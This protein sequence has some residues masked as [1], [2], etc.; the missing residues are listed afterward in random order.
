MAQPFIAVNNPSLCQ[1]GVGFSTAFDQLARVGMEQFLLWSM[2][3]GARLSPA[4]A[5][6]QAVLIIRLL[7]GGVLV[8]FTRPEF[9]PACV[10]RNAV[11]PIAIVALVLDF[12]IGGL[13]F[14]GASILSASAGVQGHDKRSLSSVAAVLI[15]WE[16]TS[17]FML[18]GLRDVS[19]L[20]RTLL[21]AVGL[22]VLIYAIT[23]LSSTLTRPKVIETTPEARSPFGVPEPVP[24]QGLRN[25]SPVVGQAY[26][27]SNLF[28]VNPSATPFDSPIHPRD[29]KASIFPNSAVETTTRSAPEGSDLLKVPTL[30]GRNSLNALPTLFRSVTAIPNAMD[31]KTGE[32]PKMNALVTKAKSSLFSHTKSPSKTTTKGFNIS[33]PIINDDQ[34][35]PGPFLRMQTIDL[36]TAVAL[37]RERRQQAAARSQRADLFKSPIQQ[38]STTLQDALQKSVSV[39]RKAVTPGSGKFP[40]ASNAPASTLAVTAADATSTSRSLSPGHEEVRRRSPRAQE[41][42]RH[43]MDEKESRASSPPRRTLAGLPH[44]PRLQQE[45]TVMLV[46]NIIYDDPITVQK[47]MSE[48]PGMYADAKLAK[49]SDEDEPGSYATGLKSSGSIIHR[50]RP[51]KRKTDDRPIFP[52]E[53]SPRHRRSRSGS[54]IGSRRSLRTIES[55]SPTEPPPLPAPPTSAANLTRIFPK[56]TKSMTVDEKIELLFPLPP[57]FPVRKERRSSV[58]SVPPL[59]LLFPDPPTKTG[60][61][62]VGRDAEQRES[63]HSR[64]STISGLAEFTRGEQAENLNTQQASDQPT[65]RFSAGAYQKLPAESAEDAYLSP[66]TF[67]NVSAS[68]GQTAETVDTARIEPKSAW[69]GTSFDETSPRL[70]TVSSKMPHVGINQ[71]MF[72]ANQPWLNRESVYSRNSMMGNSRPSQIGSMMG[73]EIMTVMLDTASA[74][75]GAQVE[76]EGPRKSYGFDGYTSQGDQPASTQ[77]WHRRPGDKLPTFSEPRTARRSRKMTPPE[78]LRLSSRGTINPI[79]IQQA[80]TSPLESPER[81]LHEIQA[82]LQN[83]EVPERDSVGSLLRHIPERTSLN[84]PSNGTKRG[85]L[86]LLNSLEN[87]LG[88]QESYW[89]QLHNT[90]D[91]DSISTTMSR[92]TSINPELRSPRASPRITAPPSPSDETIQLRRQGANALSS[93]S[94]EILLDS[95]PS[96]PKRLRASGW[97]RRLAEAES[98]FLERA[99]SLLRKQNFNFFT[100]SRAGPTPPDSEVDTASESESEIQKPPR[101]LPTKCMLWEPKKPSSPARSASQLWTSPAVLTKPVATPELPALNIR[102]NQRRDHNSLHTESASLWSKPHAHL[103]VP[104]VSLWRPKI[105]RPNSILRPRL[106]KHRPPRRSKR[107]TALPDIGMSIERR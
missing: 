68:M 48:A 76:S 31:S 97:Q 79:I 90:L 80:E 18:L 95:S 17:V 5:V 87:E 7:L 1:A 101:M 60:L 64:R 53:Q 62:P 98:E 106:V 28:I 58:P 26:T 51:Y 24:Q 45:Q 39:R 33:G 6:M 42:F 85:R 96:T 10:A 78:R 71:S 56:D 54:S 25:G 103:V 8:G 47:I 93:I 81:A 16:G 67:A 65:F 89:Q 83:F 50:P 2:S 49:I 77:Q 69:T 92:P 102:P 13:V 52:S 32:V 100:I 61:Q 66:Q 23:V 29:S 94:D 9:A 99:P 86:S 70:E 27:N 22:L 73:G 37:D 55:E 20:L 41:D 36:A 43:M 30:G 44:N 74:D 14:A 91:R 63:R 19:L 35:S 11:I 107:I 15:I 72:S 46:N 84:A 12:L 3:R 4:Q 57:A 105:G 40:N 38:S 34:G 75:M 82:R 104:F 59:P 88:Q 21:P